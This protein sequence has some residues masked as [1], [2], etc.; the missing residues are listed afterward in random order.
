MFKAYVWVLETGTYLIGSHK[1]RT[2]VET[3]V[4]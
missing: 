3:L 4:S 1:F 2:H